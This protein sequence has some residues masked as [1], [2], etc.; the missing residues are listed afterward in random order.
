MSAE[1]AFNQ[2]IPQETTVADLRKMGFDPHT[3]PNVKILTYLD[4]IHR[5]IPNNSITKADLP[6]DVLSCIESK[7]CC[8]AYE[9]DMDMTHNQRYGSVAADVFGFRKKTHITGWTFRALI[10]IKDDMV[11]YKIRSGEPLVDRYEKRTKPL[12][13]FQELDGMVARLPGMM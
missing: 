3:T 1:A 13:P 12:G 11:R 6:T 9:L 2:I 5:F 10:I 4:L 8:H 7:E